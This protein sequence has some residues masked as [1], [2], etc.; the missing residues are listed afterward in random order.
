M[1]Y[2]FQGHGIKKKKN[3]NAVIT[4]WEFSFTM[5]SISSKAEKSE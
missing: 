2:Y 5:T 3:L 1:N 4:D